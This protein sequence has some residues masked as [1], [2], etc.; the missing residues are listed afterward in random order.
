MGDGWEWGG[1]VLKHLWFCSKEKVQCIWKLPPPPT[2]TH[3]RMLYLYTIPIYMV[4]LDNVFW[5]IMMPL[6]KKMC[7]IN[8]ELPV[9]R[10]CHWHAQ[11]PPMSLTLCYR[12]M[13]FFHV[14]SRLFEW[15][16]I[17][18]KKLASLLLKCFLKIVWNTLCSFKWL[19]SKLCHC[20]F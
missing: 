18:S 6:D 13:L 14:S 12:K 10:S 8:N 9:I 5:L 15:T 17:L 1:P 2:Y 16:F 20:Q 19:L 7:V 3:T 11:I 4:D